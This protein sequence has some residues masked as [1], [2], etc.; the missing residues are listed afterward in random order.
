VIELASARVIIELGSNC[1]KV[2]DLSLGRARI[3]DKV[4]EDSV[5]GALRMTWQLF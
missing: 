4:S 2:T 1:F 3:N 5:G